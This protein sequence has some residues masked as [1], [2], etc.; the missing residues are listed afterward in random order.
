M[1]GQREIAVNVCE[2]LCGVVRHSGGDF[3]ELINLGQKPS[4]YIQFKLLLLSFYTR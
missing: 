2:T 4:H 1:V 3:R